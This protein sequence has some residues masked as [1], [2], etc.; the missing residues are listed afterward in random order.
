MGNKEPYNA[1]RFDNRRYP[2]LKKT[3]PVSQISLPKPY[4]SDYYISFDTDVLGGA[5]PPDKLRLKPRGVEKLIRYSGRVPKNWPIEQHVSCSF[6]IY[7][8]YKYIIK[9]GQLPIS[10][11]LLRILG[12]I[13]SLWKRYLLKQ[14]TPTIYKN[15][16][17]EYVDDFYRHYL[18]ILSG[19]AFVNVFEQGPA[20]ML[21]A[22]LHALT[23]KA[24][25]TDD[26]IIEDIENWVSPRT[27]MG[28]EKRLDLK[29]WDRSASKIFKTWF[30]GDGGMRPLTLTEFCNDPLR[31]GTSGGAKA[32]VFLGSKYRT[33]W[34]WAIERMTNSDGT[35]R[36]RYDLYKQAKLEYDDVAEVALKEEAQKT[37]EIITTPMPSYLRQSYLLYRWGKP[38]I[39]SPI[40][41][42]TWVAHF[43]SINPG[44]YGCL[45]GEKFDQSVPAEIILDVVDRLGALDEETRRVAD[46]E[47]RHLKKLRVHWKG[48][49]WAWLGGILSG[50]RLTSLIGSMVSVA[51]AEFIIRE[52][53]MEGGVDYGVLGDDIVL[54][55]NSLTIPKQ[56]LVDL[57]EQYGLHANMKK[58]VSGKAGEFL[59]KVVSSGGS[60]GYPALALRSVVNANPWIS[61]YSFEKEQELASTWLTYI[62]RMIPHSSDSSTLPT[63]WHEDIVADLNNSF[64]DGPWLKWLTTPQSAGGGGPVELM[65]WDW[66]RLEH[67]P[68]NRHDSNDATILPTLLGVL[69]SKLVFKKVPTFRPIN[70][71]R[72]IV[73]AAHM[74]DSNVNSPVPGFRKDALGLPSLYLFLEK[75]LT[76]SELQ[77]KLTSPLPRSVRGEKREAIVRFLLEARSDKVGYVSIVHTKESTA[78]NSALSK[79]VSR[80][81]SVSKRFNTPGILGPATTIYFLQ[82]YL[83]HRI[84]AGTW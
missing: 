47:I 63:T 19:W 71:S 12:V 27:N 46:E 31:W 83:K 33:K 39:N 35:L 54:Y 26:Q 52:S 73:D 62:S 67:E 22:H 75:K 20:Y 29:A 42:A 15:A 53:G 76:R 58:T 51:A 84:P 57:Y 25:Y 70:I 40:S 37:R 30:K 49:T 1:G 3:Y 34:A 28:K 2:K 38:N 50:W 16:P 36:D 14:T 78:Y 44:W 74:Q 7:L 21:L 82:T 81:V 80:A 11:V 6:P 18:K 32:T 5:Q 72:A 66:V 65:K 59:R 69:K 77:S 45:D 23:G 24:P 60:W 61:S 64:G 4:Q 17:G 41:S 13:K 43:E 9:V 48:K 8:H 10:R 68:L 56:E 55:A 79:Y